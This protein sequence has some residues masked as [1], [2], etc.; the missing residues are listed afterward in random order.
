VLF[1]LDIKEGAGSREGDS[2]WRVVGKWQKKQE[3][4]L[5]G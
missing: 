3:D 5:D 4:T 2:T 1:N